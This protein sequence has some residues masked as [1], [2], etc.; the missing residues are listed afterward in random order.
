MTNRRSNRIAIAHRAVTA[1]KRCGCPDLAWHTSKRT[2]RPYLCQ[3]LYSS[4]DAHGRIEAVM[5]TSA[6]HNCEE[7]KAAMA[8]YETTLCPLCNVRRL[9]ADHLAHT[10]ACVAK[11]LSDADYLAIAREDADRDADMIARNEAHQEEVDR[12]QAERDFDEAHPPR[13]RG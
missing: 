7:Y 9:N 8:I 3:V 12:Q 2:G 11:H 1:C 5:I 4:R 6:A 10:E 13:P